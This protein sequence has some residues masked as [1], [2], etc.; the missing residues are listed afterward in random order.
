MSH[1]DAIEYGK[2]I[3][4]LREEKH[5]TQ[6]NLVEA[7]GYSDASQIQRIEAGERFFSSSHT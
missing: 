5:M 6:S 2:R 7:V 4:D 1:F 3:K